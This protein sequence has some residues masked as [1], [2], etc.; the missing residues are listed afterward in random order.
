MAAIIPTYLIVK[1]WY[2][3][4]TTTTSTVES[5]RSGGTDGSPL[6]SLACTRNSSERKH[7]LAGERGVGPEKES[8]VGNVL[9]TKD[10]M[11]TLKWR[12]SATIVADTKVVYPCSWGWR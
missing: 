8:A 9:E 12:R 11:E 1:T 6:P 5:V 3:D 4:S 2:Q 10:E 7:S